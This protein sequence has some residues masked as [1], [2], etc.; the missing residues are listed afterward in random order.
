[1]APPSAWQTAGLA[2]LCRQPMKCALLSLLLA[3]SCLAAEF[4]SPGPSAPRL[5]L[6]IETD[7]GGDPDDEQ[8][9]VRFLL[10]TCEWNVEAIIANRPQTRRPENSNPAVTGL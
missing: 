3:A 2:S 5:R 10:Y 6:I 7:A 8:S 1:G 9:L 4:S